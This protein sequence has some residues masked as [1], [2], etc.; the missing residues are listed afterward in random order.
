MVLLSTGFWI[1][2]DILNEQVSKAPT[3]TKY[4]NGHNS[5]AVLLAASLS[6]NRGQRHQGAEITCKSVRR[7]HPHGGAW[8]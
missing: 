5:T 7:P 3:M 4:L 1:K 2:L 6:G 8:H